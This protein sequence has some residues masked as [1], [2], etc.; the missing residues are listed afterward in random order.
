MTK[1]LVLIL[2]RLGMVNVAAQNVGQI[3]KLDG[4]VRLNRNQAERPLAVGEWLQQ[5]DTIM[6]GTTGSVGITFIDNSRF[7]ASPNTT[8]D[9]QSFQ[10]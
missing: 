1:P 2:A 5:A 8:L 10:L 6:T 9:L 3:K 7:S 4:D